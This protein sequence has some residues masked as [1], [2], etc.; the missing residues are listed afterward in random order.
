[1]RQNHGSSREGIA[2]K[3]FGGVGRLAKCHNR[4]NFYQKQKSAVKWH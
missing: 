3:S 4:I 2:F 1:M